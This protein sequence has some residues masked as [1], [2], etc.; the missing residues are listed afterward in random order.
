MK[1][2]KCMCSQSCLNAIYG[3]APFNDFLLVI[4]GCPKK[5]WGVEEV[6]N[7]IYEFYIRCSDP[8]ECK[9]CRASVVLA[10]SV[11]GFIVTREAVSLSFVG[12]SAVAQTPIPQG[13]SPIEALCAQNIWQLGKFKVKFT[14]Y[15]IAVSLHTKYLTLHTW[16]NWKSHLLPYMKFFAHKVSIIWK[17]W[18]ALLGLGLGFWKKEN[19]KST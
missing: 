8:H 12:L 6:Y 3:A 13:S 1:T 18:I 7:H 16:Q 4:V 14:S 9:V 10:K 17:N 19:Q 11:T 5:R 2:W 15:F